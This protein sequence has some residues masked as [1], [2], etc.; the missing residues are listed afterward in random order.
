[1]DYYWLLQTRDGE[2]HYIP[3]TAVEN[4]KGKLAQNQPIQ[5][6]T[7]VV[8]ANQVTKFAL[9]DRMYGRQL[10]TDEVAAVFHEPQYN[11]DG[12]VVCRWVKRRVTSNKWDKHYSHHRY[13]RLGEENN[14]VLM[15]MFLPIH[16]INLEEV[17]YCTESEV[18]K[19]EQ[20]R[21]S[22]NN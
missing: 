21:Q 3:P 2:H 1:M 10:L 8:P 5:L 15:A 4:I 6:R 14:M 20:Q 13:Y 16:Q 22:D 12:S 7:A 17:Q 11:K 18:R 19:L 9:S